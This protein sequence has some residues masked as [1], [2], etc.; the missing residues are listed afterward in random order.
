MNGSSLAAEAGQDAEDLRAGIKSDVDQYA[1]LRLA[2][3]VL[4]AGIER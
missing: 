4:R 1:R 3:A 2:S